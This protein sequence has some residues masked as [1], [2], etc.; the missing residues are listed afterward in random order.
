MLGCAV[1]LGEVQNR[2]G[3]LSILE[4]RRLFPF[5]QRVVAD[6]AY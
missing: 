2:N 6:G 4:M 5:L 3:C 1:L